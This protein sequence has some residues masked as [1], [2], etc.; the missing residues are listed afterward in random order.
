MF[1]KGQVVDGGRSVTVDGGVRSLFSFHF[2]R[3]VFLLFL[4][5]V[6]DS[7]CIRRRKRRMK[8]THVISE[9]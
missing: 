6:Y 3:L 5:Q 7:L 2:P 4:V 8:H 1:G 9:V